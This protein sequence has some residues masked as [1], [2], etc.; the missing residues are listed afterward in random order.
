[1]C[2]RDRKAEVC[3]MDA[4]RVMMLKLSQKGKISRHE[5]NERIGELLLSLIHI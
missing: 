5:I 4:L 1:M 2:I 3:Y